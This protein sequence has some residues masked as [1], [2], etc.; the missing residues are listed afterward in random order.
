M[1]A[2]VAAAVVAGGLAATASAQDRYTD[3]GGT[4]VHGSNIEALDILGVFDGTQCGARKFCPG[5][6]A[7]RWEVAVWIVRVIDGQDPSPVKESRFADVDDDEWWMP[8]VERLYDLGITTG[9][10]K[11]PLRYCPD[12]SVSRAQMASFLVRA[13]RL[14]RASSA[15]FADTRGNR[16]EENIDAVFAAGITVGCKQRPARFCPDKS[17]TRAHMATFL[18]RGLTNA[19]RT[20]IGGGRPT[21]GTNTGGTTGPGTITNSQGPR[22]GDT[23]IA[24]IRGRTCAIRSDETVTCW[25]GD[26]GYR[27]HLS[28]ADLVDVVALSI[29]DHPSDEL[30]SCAV[31]DN[32][33]VSC[34]GA[35]SEGQLGQGNT[36]SYYLPQPVSDVRDAVA[37][38][39]GAGFTCAVHRDGDVS[40]WGANNLGQLG[41]GTTYSGS[42]WPQLIIRRFDA[43]AISAGENHSCAIH[44]NGA[45][46]CWGGVYGTRPST[47]AVPG[48]VTSVSMG[49][50]ETC[51]TTADGRVFC[52]DLD[53]SRS[54]GMTQVANISDAVKV[55]VGNETACVLHLRGGVSCW[56][57]NDVGQV[58]DG[59]TTRRHAPVRLNTITNAIDISVSP[60]SATVGAHACALHS[61]RSVSCWGG[62]N[63]GQLAD[64][65]VTNRLTPTP[66]QLLSR[67]RSLE[68]PRT[69][70][71]LLLD[72]IDRVVDNRER[73]FPWLREAWDHIDTSTRAS[74]TASTAG[75]GGDIT[76]ACTTNPL[77]GCAVTAMTITD[78]S[79]GTVIR[80]LA[81]VYDLGI[82][83]GEQ[84]GAV[85][86]Y[87]A[88][89]YPRC[90][91]GDYLHG[92]Q[93]LADTLLHVTAPHAWLPY[94]QGG[95][96]R[97]CTGLPSTPTR[98]AEQVVSQGLEDRRAPGRAPDWYYTNI[99]S[100]AELWT[101]WRNNPSL[102]ALD[103]LLR[104]EYGGLCMTWIQDWIPTP[105]T[106]ATALPNQI[107]TQPQFIDAGC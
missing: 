18:N 52:W 67:I 90:S 87:F 22:S 63:V 104:V 21:D 65:T 102:P 19:G 6:L 8:Y 74:P 4:S 70:N 1:A 64:G 47:V 2:T 76:F 30:H 5:E 34:W 85:Q 57:R 62:N 29:S 15:N 9:C 33:D 95:R 80:Q 20:I 45:L 25:G 17:T 55:S 39:A 92:A 59:T 96:S 7:R 24:A 48:D 97:D 31:H 60:G 40:C 13:F 79:V 58:G 89:R 23:Q 103:N 38:A 54:P 50:V 35:G 27:E 26:D 94:Y 84:W 56:G 106:P 93:V 82:A 41:D 83:A 86:L 61:N 100:A 98:E 78:M 11:D 68:L 14:Q 51:I 81:R 75:A 73:R 53:A 32:G 101:T 77:S 99:T 36:N 10:E 49:G 16:H 37:V 43:V 46:S 91:P 88:S 12:D 44:R 3:V 69:E 107:P 42:N 28:A 66:V 72:F 71:A 105:G